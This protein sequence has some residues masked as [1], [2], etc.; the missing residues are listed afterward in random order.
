MNIL[1]TA[2]LIDCLN[3]WH[4]DMPDWDL[5]DQPVEELSDESAEEGDNE[6][7]LAEE[8]PTPSTSENHNRGQKK[9]PKPPKFKRVSPEERKEI[10][11]FHESNLAS[12]KCI[13]KKEAV[14]YIRASKSK[15]EWEAVKVVVNNKV[16]Y[17]QRQAK[18]QKKKKD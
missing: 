1:L 4:Q 14:S 13:G 9:V 7:A 2:A 8:E 11:K 16:Q 17:L 12:K 3:T 10:L 15:L 6:T 5:R 18:K